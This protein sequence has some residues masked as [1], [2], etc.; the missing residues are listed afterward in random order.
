M[1][2]KTAEPL[3]GKRKAE[4]T[5]IQLDTLVNGRISNQRWPIARDF[6]A[7]ERPQGPTDED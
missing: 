7:F 6:A 2:T 5:S 1:L 4:N 3:N